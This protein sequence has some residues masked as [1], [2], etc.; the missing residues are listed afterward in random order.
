[1]KKKKKRARNKKRKYKKM[2]MICQCYYCMK[3]IERKKANSL[4]PM[5]RSKG[6]CKNVAGFN[7]NN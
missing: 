5:I 2:G 7:S 4:A 1:M 3:R 6:D